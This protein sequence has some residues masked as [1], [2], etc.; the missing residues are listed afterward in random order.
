MFIQQQSAP[1]NT[2][3]LHSTLNFRFIFKNFYPSISDDAYACFLLIHTT[4]RPILLFS[5]S[6]SRIW[7]MRFV[8]CKMVFNRSISAFMCSQV[9]FCRG[10]CS[11]CCQFFSQALRFRVHAFRALLPQAFYFRVHA[12]ADFVM[13]VILFHDLLRMRAISASLN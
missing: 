9:S 13:Q 3:I 7:M 5:P 2:S 12:Y 10:L 1:Q 4:P 8:S 6:G 11:L